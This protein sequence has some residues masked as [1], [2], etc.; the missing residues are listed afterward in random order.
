M[1][2][3]KYKRRI[4]ELEKEIERVKDRTKELGEENDRT[5]RILKNSKPGEITYDIDHNLWCG[6]YTLHLYKDFREYKFNDFAP[7]CCSICNIDFTQGD[8]P[9]IIFANIIYKFY[10]VK[11]KITCVLDLEDLSCCKIKEEVIE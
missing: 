3:R 7:T 6:S 8:L 11:K 9:N 4:E 2:F 1:F 10:S 5:E